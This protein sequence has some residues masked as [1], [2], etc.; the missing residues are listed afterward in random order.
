MASLLKE[1]ILGGERIWLK[2]ILL[3]GAGEQ[4]SVPT[5]NSLLCWNRTIR[6]AREA[7][8]KAAAY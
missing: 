8:V 1:L 3:T 4:I 7:R 6:I 2:L 5:S